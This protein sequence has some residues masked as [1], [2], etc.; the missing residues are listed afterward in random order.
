MLKTL[1]RVFGS[2]PRPGTRVLAIMVPVHL[3][4]F[5]L[6]YIATLSIVQN[7][8]LQTHSRDAKLLLEEAVRDLHPLMCD[9]EAEQIPLV[10]RSFV[11]SHQVLDLNIFRSTGELMSELDAKPNQEI[12]SFLAANGKDTFQTESNSDG[13]TVLNGLMRIRSVGQCTDCHTPNET[14]GA[15]TMRLDLTQS[16]GAARGRLERHLGVL[17]VSWAALVGFVNLGLRV[18]TRR[19]LIRFEKSGEKLGAESADSGAVPSLILDPVSEELFESLK[20]LHEKQK[21]K[22]EEVSCRL[23]HAEHMASLGQLA[24]GLAHEIKNPLAGIRGVLELLRDESEEEE[25][26]R[27][28]QQMVGELDRVNTTIHGLLHYARPAPPKPVATDVEG[29]LDEVFGL[30]NPGLAK[31]QIRL[32]CSAAADL[33]RFNLDPSQIKQVLVNLI[34]NAAD[35][36]ENDGTVSVTASLFPRGDGLILAVKDD[37][38]GIPEE[39]L[40]EIFEPFYTTKFTGTGLGLSVA[41]SLVERAGGKLQVSS[42]TGQGTTFF[43]LLPTPE[44]APESER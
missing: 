7:E 41:Q 19:S 11:S 10:V 38:P 20:R 44:T 15:A 34:T 2:F 25:K 30:L 39:N 42:E 12:V 17:I 22:D 21:S 18:W 23:L 4:A 28:F 1:A 27:L 40:I 3:G 37:G 29:L 26:T 33:P 31:Q 13:D 6:L 24:A 5:V 16:I 14:L 8:I 43:I 36:I 32:T 35:A 9:H